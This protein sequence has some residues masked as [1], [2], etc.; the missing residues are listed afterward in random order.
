MQRPRGSRRD[1]DCHWCEEE[2]G[3]TCSLGGCCE[4]F[5]FAEIAYP[6]TAALQK[7]KA[8]VTPDWLRDSVKAG[9]CLPCEAYIAIEDLHEATVQNCPDCNLHPCAC[10]DS[11]DVVEQETPPSTQYPSPPRSQSGSTAEPSPNKKR[12]SASKGKGKLLQTALNFPSV[13]TTAEVKV[14]AHL[15]PPDPPIPTNVSKLS[16]NSRYAVQR[17][18]P[19]I[20]PNQGLALEL[21]IIK[22]SRGLEGEERSQLSYARA[23][24]VIKGF[25]CRFR[26]AM[27]THSSF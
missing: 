22:R 10:D 13:G 24:S 11:D 8:V 9:K 25:F 15:L 19:L 3:E 21:D 27:A 20:C 1:L 23:I 17:A 16:Y 12:K 18:S 2:A 5:G 4:S 14:P 26:R 7:T 6:L